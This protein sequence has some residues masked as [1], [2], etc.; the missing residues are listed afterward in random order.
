MA[1][2]KP[3]KTKSKKKEQQGKKD[4]KPSPSPENKQKPPKTWVALRLSIP[5]L[6]LIYELM[7][8]VKWG[9][10]KMSKYDQRKDRAKKIIKMAKKVM[11]KIEDKVLMVEDKD[12]D[13]GNK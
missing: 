4:V 12:K 1:K 5:E 9:Y 11:G 6:T 3:K 8:D 7:H 10:Q 13:G 2:V